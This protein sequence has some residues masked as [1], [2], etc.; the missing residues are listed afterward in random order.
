MKAEIKLNPT[1][2]SIPKYGNG[3]MLAMEFLAKWATIMPTGIYDVGERIEIRLPLT[4]HSIRPIK[5]YINDN[6]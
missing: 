4:N 1:R 3:L 2:I 5:K 6:L